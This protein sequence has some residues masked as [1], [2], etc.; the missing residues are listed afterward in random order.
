MQLELSPIRNESEMSPIGNETR[1][2]MRILSLVA[3]LL[4][5]LAITQHQ[6]LTTMNCRE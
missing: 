2:I 4:V 6:A 3:V 1:V 5:G